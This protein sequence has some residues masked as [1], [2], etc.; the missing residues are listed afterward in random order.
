LGFARPNQTNSV[1]T[2]WATVG[3]AIGPAQFTIG[4]ILFR[5]KPFKHLSKK[6]INK[7]EYQKMTSINKNY[8]NTNILKLKEQ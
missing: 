4:S 7:S 1:G 8:R 3:W 6:T 2:G 5:K